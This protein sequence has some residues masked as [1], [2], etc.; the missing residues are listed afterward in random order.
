MVRVTAWLVHT[1]GFCLGP[2]LILD[3]VS[4]IRVSTQAVNQLGLAIMV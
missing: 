4:G 2:V 3:D 1:T